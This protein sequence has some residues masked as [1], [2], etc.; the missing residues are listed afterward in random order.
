MV[1]I[2]CNLQGNL[3][4]NKQIFHQL[5]FWFCKR[6]PWHHQKY[7]YIW[8]TFICTVWKLKSRNGVCMNYSLHTSSTNDLWLSHEAYKCLYHSKCVL[9]CDTWLWPWN[10]ISYFTGTHLTLNIS[11]ELVNS[12]CMGKFKEDSSLTKTNSAYTKTKR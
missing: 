6:F 1:M 5:K 8:I 11:I 12:I 9:I 4:K 10:N 3:R 7:K 2:P